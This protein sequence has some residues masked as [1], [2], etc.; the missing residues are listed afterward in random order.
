MTKVATVVW[1]CGLPGSGKT[2]IAK[3][4]LEAI[5]RAKPSLDLTLV[6]MDSIRQKIFPNPT[7]S[8]EERDTA[9]RA[10]VLLASLLSS[11][12]IPVLLDA[13]GHKKVWRDLARKECARFVEVYIKCPIE[14]CI[15]RETKRMDGA[16]GIR[17]TLYLD[18]LDRLKSGKKE[19][20]LG[21]VPGVDEPFE[22]YESPEITLDSSREDPK[23]LADKTLRGLSK[24]D[25]EIFSIS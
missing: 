23:I 2:T 9:Y 4:V 12:G 1:F 25:P 15:E 20:G 6:S 8:D 10:L 24:F 22:E 5:T 11:Y 17:R 16:T 13:T 14:I 7:Y 19:K 21:K 18:A 3:G